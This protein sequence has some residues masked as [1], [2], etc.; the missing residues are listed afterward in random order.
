MAPAE[1]KTES[2]ASEKESIGVFVCHCGTNIGGVVNCEKVAETIS[3]V[4]GVAISRDLKYACS[5][6]GQEEIRKAI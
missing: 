6:L 5:D 2:K 4:P 3:K 1:T